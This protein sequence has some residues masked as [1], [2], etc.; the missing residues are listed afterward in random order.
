MAVAGGVAGSKPARAQTSSVQIVG[1]AFQP[2]TMTIPVGATVTWTNQDAVQ[3]TSTSDTGLWNSGPLDQGKSFSFTFTQPGTYAYHCAIHP[4]MTASIT[5]QAQGATTAPTTAATS[6]ATPTAGPAA[7]A[8]STPEPTATN[9]APAPPAPPAVHALKVSVKGTLRSGRASNLTVNVKDASSG[10][11][12]RHARVSLD[13]RS[14][15]VVHVLS[16]T[17][18]KGGAAAFKGVEARRAGKATLKVTRTG[19]KA[20][21][22]TIRVR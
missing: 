12:V 10:S 9:T 7:P 3:H 15:G 17:T 4:Y 6:T 1:F 19:Y 18:G 8:T 11:A 2:A 16:A 20:W 21:S 14:V 5:V 22:K 13:A